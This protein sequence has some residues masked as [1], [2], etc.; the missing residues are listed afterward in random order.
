MTRADDVVV[1]TGDGYDGHGSLRTGWGQDRPARSSIDIN[2]P[3]RGGQGAGHGP[4][5]GAPMSNRSAKPPSRTCLSDIGPA[6]AA[7][8]PSGKTPP[9]RCISSVPSRT[10]C[11]C[12]SIA[13]T[14]PGCWRPGRSRAG[15]RASPEP[16]RDQRIVCKKPHRGIVAFRPSGGELPQEPAERGLVPEHRIGGARRRNAGSC[17]HRFDVV[18][19]Q[20]LDR[21]LESADVIRVACLTCIDDEFE[22]LSDRKPRG[23]GRGYGRGVVWQ[24]RAR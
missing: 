11:P 20:V 7:H 24:A 15:T 14:D 23:V 22:A 10:A 5:T 8:P 4:Q 2:R 16:T 3:A 1:T 13:S 12:G 9:S 17:R 6:P 18:C 19:L 21:R